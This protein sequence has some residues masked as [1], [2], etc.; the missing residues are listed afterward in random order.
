MIALFRASKNGSTP[1]REDDP[2]DDYQDELGRESMLQSVAQLTRAI[3]SRQ[4][5][6]VEVLTT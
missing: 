5:A 1:A 2:F 4:A 6:Q 3:E